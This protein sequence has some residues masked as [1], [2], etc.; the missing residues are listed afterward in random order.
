MAKID[1]KKELKAFNKPSA[2]APG[3]A[4]IPEINFLMVDGSGN[5]NT[6]QS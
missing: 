3:I 6:A 5:P 1:Y 2:K 4:N